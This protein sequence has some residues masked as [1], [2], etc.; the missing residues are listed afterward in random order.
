VAEKLIQDFPL[1][2]L[3]SNVGGKIESNYLPFLVQSENEELILTTHLARSNPQWKNLGSNVLVSFQGPNRYISPVMYSGKNNVPTWNYAAVQIEGSPELI[4][5]G[6]EIKKILSQSVGFFES[7]NRSNWRYNLPQEMQ[8]RL[9]S[10]IIGLRIRA[11][12]KAKF[13]LSQ[14]RNDEDYEAVIGYL[15]TSIIASDQELL[16]WMKRLPK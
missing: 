13:K 8:D 6:A 4:T 5:E 16:E 9:E 3:I 10:A 11:K 14:N 15:K 2:L 1:G 7:R 12:G